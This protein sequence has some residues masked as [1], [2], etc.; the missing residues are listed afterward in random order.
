ML[1]S[2]S[3]HSNLHSKRKGAS[4]CFGSSRVSQRTRLAAWNYQRNRIVACQR[5]DAHQKLVLKGVR[6]ISLFSLEDRNHVVFPVRARENHLK[7]PQLPLPTPFGVEDAGLSRIRLYVLLWSSKGYDLCRDPQVLIVLRRGVGFLLAA[8]LP[9][10]LCSNAQTT[11]NVLLLH[12]GNANH[13]ANV[14][15]SGVFHQFISADPRN[16]FFE[17]YMDEDRLGA[18]EAGLAEALRD[19]YLGQKMAL[20]IGD[21]RPA[22][23]FLMKRGEDLW[24]GTPKVFYFVDSRELPAKL[25]PNMTGV[26]STVDYGAILD[27]A[28]QLK[29]DTR[30]VFY[31]GGVNAWEET[32][33]AFAGQDFQRF[34]G[35][36]EVTYLN[37]LPFPEMLDRLGRLPDHSAVIYSE[38][39]QDASGHVYVPGRIC[40]L[41]AS[42]S[43]AP[44]YGPFDTYI[45]CGVVGGVIIDVKD[46]AAQTAK[47]GLRVLERGSTS[48]F[49]VERSSNQVVV[50]WRQL[51]RWGISEER[52]PMGTIMQFRTPSLWEEYKW[53]ILAALTMI[54]VQLA[55]IIILILEMRRRK[56]SDLVIKNLSGRLINAGEEE[57]KRIARELHDDIVQRLSLVSVELS[58]VKR[59]IPTEDSAAHHS[60]HER[61]QQ[62]KGII[63]DVHNL[64]HQLHSSNLEVLGLVAALD[65]LCQQLSRRED[66]R[67][68][69]IADDI[70]S[71][72]SQDLALCF[73]R[74][75][76]EALNNSAKHSGSTRAEVRLTAYDG[77]LKMTIRDYGAGFDP[78]A[79]ANGLGLATMRE[80]L[81]FVDGKL[82]VDSKPSGGTEVTAL[83][84]LE[85]TSQRTTIV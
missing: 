15:T 5:I 74:V 75:A 77:T 65:E 9:F 7:G 69:L 79:A 35:R 78:S 42:A 24:P 50:D 85:S 45:G 19:K 82:L 39:L 18:S 63:T 14:I 62:L 76:Q 20:V 22:L 6:H 38:L 54:M 37:D 70:P 31:I 34:A 8:A 12:E 56:K 59:D 2:Y 46:L 64:S 28:L 47:L 60:L 48:G 57:R 44:V 16:Q 4:G 25:P 41:I 32:W 43:N 13:P 3:W 58:L 84:R 27:L 81:R 11:R 73:Y 53:L 61:L 49:P 10:S 67:A 71:P 26:V 51:Q 21:G 23:Q 55:L 1:A 80:R 83:A 52:L 68:Q 17:E 33:R 36:V 40:P 72:I 30:R 29:P 66:M